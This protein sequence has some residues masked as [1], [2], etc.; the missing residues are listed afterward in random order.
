[1]SAAVPSTARCSRHR[2]SLSFVAGCQVKC[3][4]R[5]STRGYRE[6]GSVL[7]VGPCKPRPLRMNTDDPPE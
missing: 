6:N 3:D 2:P 1:M 7:G 5:R 4:G